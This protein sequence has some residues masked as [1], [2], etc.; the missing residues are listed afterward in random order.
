ME[1]RPLR[2]QPAGASHLAQRRITKKL[3]LLNL[4]YR[5]ASEKFMRLLWADLLAT[6]QPGAGAEG[7]DTF[8]R[9]LPRSSL[10]ELG[11]KPPGPS[12]LFFFS[13]PEEAGGSTSSIYCIIPF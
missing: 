1:Q 13:N 2:S 3:Q 6:R 5:G 12:S 9:D 8:V 7:V 11:Q 4:N 10:D